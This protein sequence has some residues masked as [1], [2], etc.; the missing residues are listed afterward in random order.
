MESSK[1][2]AA[3]SSLSPD[4]WDTHVH[5]FDASIGPFAPGRSY[6]PARATAQQLLDF[7]FSL[8]QE[9]PLNIV[10]VQPSPYG[11]DNTVLL[12]SMKSLRE[13][14]SRIVR[15]IA[16]VDIE[17]I[18]DANLM[19]LH[20][21]GVRGLR[22]NKQAD[23]KSTDLKALKE[24][25][26][27]TASRIQYLPGWKIQLF[28]APAM[29]EDLYDTIVA[30][31][32]QVIADHVG[33]MRALSKLQL[34]ATTSSLDDPTKQP[35]FEAL[36][37]LARASKAIVKL[38]GF[39]RLSDK[40]ES[41]CSDMEPIVKALV[42][43]V[44]HRLVWGSDWPH[45]GEGK[46]RVNRGLEAVEEFREID[47]SRIIQNLRS[48]VEDEKAWMGLMVQNPAGFYA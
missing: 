10:L 32:V 6:T 14:G 4:S 9:T 16:V 43:A 38:S 27:Q 20:D 7:S 12:R 22:I 36:V 44:P 25:I 17:N 40:T 11:S 35:G 31:P 46:D 34:N 39:Y 30:L 8:T 48:W 1:F 24:T 26:L 37:K 2:I 18:S 47:D 3:C 41:G 33:G 28:C 5:V 45:T 19:E 23:G 21:A 13:G 29:W 42:E 15:G